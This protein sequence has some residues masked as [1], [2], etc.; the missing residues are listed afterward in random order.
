MDFYNEAARDAFTL[1]KEFGAAC[2]VTKTPVNRAVNPVTATFTDSPATQQGQAF[3]VVLPLTQH[4]DKRFKD[5][6]VKGSLRQIL[7]EAE[8]LP[9]EPEEGD[10]ITQFSQNFTIHSL[11]PLKPANKAVLYTIVAEKI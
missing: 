9:F 5:A 4:A 11:T 8:S 1:I 7:M 10:N 3:A 6:L 2:T